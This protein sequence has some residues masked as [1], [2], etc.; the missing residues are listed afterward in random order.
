ML[1]VDILQAFGWFMPSVSF[2]RLRYSSLEYPV[3]ALVVTNRRYPPTSCELLQCNY[4]TCF[5]CVY[6]FFCYE[7]LSSLSSTFLFLCVCT[8]FDV[9]IY[10]PNHKMEKYEQ[11]ASRLATMFSSWRRYDEGRQELMKRQLTRIRNSSPSKDT[12]EVATR[13]L[14]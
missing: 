2:L 11:V 6:A 8:L 3:M 12:Y 10:A 7:S 13:C 1:C 5:W 9:P 14:G 4:S